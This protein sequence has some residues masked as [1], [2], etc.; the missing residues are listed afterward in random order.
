MCSEQRPVDISVVI[1]T[2]FHAPYIAQCLESVL[3]QETDLNVEIL[4]G[5]DASQDG[6]AEVIESYVQRYPERIQA[7]FHEKNVG[8]TRNG[9]DVGRLIRGKYVAYLEGDDYWLDPRKLQKQWDILEAHPEYSACYGKCLVID[10]NGQPDYTRTAHFVWNRKIYTMDDLVNTW[11]IPGQMSTL[12]YRTALKGVAP[13]AAALAYQAHPIVGDKTQTLLLLAHGPIYCSGDVLS[14]YRSV[15]KSGGH[16]WFSIHHANPYR[17]YDMFMYPCKLETWA[18]KHMDLPRDKHFGKRSE[19]RF[20]RFVE[21]LVKEPSWTRVKYLA[22]MVRHSHQP[23]RYT[24]MI[25][26]ALI[27]ME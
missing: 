14:C 20:C 26:K 22:E 16:N 19:Y 6:T 9:G 27:E 4:V 15:D 12:M 2:Y 11:N 7:V 3:A 17:N 21:E 24:W 13:E 1:L 5:D 25:L 8:A 10:E 23:A 18:R